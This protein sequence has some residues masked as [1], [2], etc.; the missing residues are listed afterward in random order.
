MRFV[1]SSK[2]SW[3]HLGVSPLRRQFFPLSDAKFTLN[4]LCC[5]DT[6]FLNIRGL[7]CRLLRLV[8]GTAFY[9]PDISYEGANN[10]RYIFRS[11]NVRLV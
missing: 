1:H 5:S 8:R 3:D 6:C 4:V 2:P 10:L 9:T 11:A 7:S